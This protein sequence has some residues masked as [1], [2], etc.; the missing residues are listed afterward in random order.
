MAMVIF[1]GKVEVLR[2]TEGTRDGT[3]FLLRAHFGQHREINEEGQTTDVFH[4]CRSPHMKRARGKGNRK[5]D[6]SDGFTL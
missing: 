5:T 4:T 6:P 3:Q 2:T 1:D